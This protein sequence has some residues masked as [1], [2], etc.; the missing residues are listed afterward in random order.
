ME[1]V[2][3]FKK[4][5]WEWG[6]DWKKFKDAPHFQKTFGYTTTQLKKIPLVNG[7]PQI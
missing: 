7:Y 3:I 1:C 4:Y 6:G 2:A 5:G